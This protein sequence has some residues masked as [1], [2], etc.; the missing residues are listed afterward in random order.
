MAQFRYNE[1]SFRFTEPVRL[2]KQNDPY[3]FEVDNIPIKQLQE[4]CLWLKDQLQQSITENSVQD[5]KRQDIAELK[6][7]ATGGDRLVRVMPGRFTARINDATTKQPL[8]YLTQVMGDAMGDVDA[9]S[10]RTNNPGTPNNSLLAAALDRFKSSLASNALAMNGLAE[11]AFT[12][13]VRDVDYVGDAGGLTTGPLSYLGATGAGG[14]GPFVISQALLW[15]KSYNS[16]TDS[17][18]IPSYSTT[19]AVVGFGKLPLSETHF[20]KKWRGVSRLSV[21]DVPNEL[22]VEVP[23]FS[24]DDFYYIDESGS[25][26]NI[27]NVESRIDLVFLY[28][29]PVDA[30]SAKVIRGGVASD[31]TA[32]VLGIVRGAGIGANFQGMVD[33]DNSYRA[34]PALDEYGNSMI[35]PHAADQ[36][37]ANLGFLA[38]A[39]NELTQ[40]V[41]G[42][43]PSPDDLL[44]LAPLI[45]ES[46]ETNAVELVGQSILPVAYVF[47]QRA[48]SSDTEGAMVLENSDV[49]DIRPFF[50]TAELAYNERA[51]IAAALPQLSLANPAVGKAQLDT[52]LRKVV[53]HFNGVMASEEN[54]Q[55]NVSVVAAGYVF[56]GWNFGPEGALYDFYQSRFAG[57]SITT[58]D[59]L[60]YIRQY[61]IGKYGV[62]SNGAQISI[63]SYPDWDMSQWCQLQDL[64]D[65]GLWPNDYI[66]TFLGVTESGGVNDAAIVAGSNK[67]VT[68]ADGTGP[69]GAAAPTRLSGFTNTETGDAYSKVNFH[70]ISKRIKFNR[71]ACPWLADYMVDVEFANCLPQVHRGYKLNDNSPM[72]SQYAGVWVEK[73]YDDFVIYV[74]FAANDL[75]QAPNVPRFPSPH[76]L[77]FT[78]TGKKKKTTQTL[79][80]SERGGG[81]FSSFIVPVDDIL[82]SDTTPISELNGLGYTGN[83]RVGKCTYPTVTWKMIGI[84][85]SDSQYLYGNLNSTNPTITL[86]PQS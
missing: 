75:Y 43:F 52:E 53:N 70:Y 68:N 33:I 77:S 13:S 83:P 40:D 60:Q 9:W 85:T 84:P 39:N 82:T 34:E 73:G 78:T 79:S 81:R 55:D 86:K 32:P 62:G 45:A 54:D 72:P 48:G 5:V 74:A 41:R 66:N 23:A 49:V 4:N 11:R 24:D 10:A 30:P 67:E 71:D 69:D 59:S 46:L 76:S 2:F 42:S 56:G 51:G 31:I 37:A 18:L 57:D 64:S 80:V 8:Q 29:K 61:I 20:V 47:I 15:A 22:S 17:Y 36:N 16:V 28:S 25:R 7:Y 1:S 63:P 6:P 58:N 50:R 38:T 3:Y 65:K 27:Q 12:W 21:V 19:N 14:Y 26:I 35:L 44:N